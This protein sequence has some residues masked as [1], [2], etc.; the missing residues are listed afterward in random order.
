MRMVAPRFLIFG[1]NRRDFT[2]KEALLKP[3]IKESYFL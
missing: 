1:S 3:G 2:G